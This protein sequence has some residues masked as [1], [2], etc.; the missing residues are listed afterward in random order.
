MNN[1]EPAEP[2][3]THPDTESI[4]DLMDRVVCGRA[5]PREENDYVVHCECDPDGYRQLALAM[6]E[7]RRINQA[8]GPMVSPT[9]RRSG[10]RRRSWSRLT[11][12]AATAAVAT[13]MIVA[14]YRRGVRDAVVNIADANTMSHSVTEPTI[15]NPPDFADSH[16]GGWIAVVQPPAEPVTVARRR[17]DTSISPQTRAIFRQLGFDVRE[18]VRAVLASD[19]NGEATLLPDRHFQIEPLAAS[20]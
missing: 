3:Q 20:F 17:I 6:L 12:I 4:A 15:E 18:E 8:M 19:P 2:S 16:G 9:R 14:S 11:M 13:L 7:R 1:L 5:T 10:S